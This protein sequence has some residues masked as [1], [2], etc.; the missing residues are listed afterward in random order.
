MKFSTAADNA[1]VDAYFGE[2]EQYDLEVC[3]RKPGSTSDEWINSVSIAGLFSSTGNNEGYSFVGDTANVFQGGTCAVNL[4]P[5][6][7][8]TN[9]TEQWAIFVDWNGDGAFVASERVFSG[10]GN[11][12][13]SGSFV[14]PASIPAGQYLMRV[15]MKYGSAPEAGCFVGFYYGEMED[16]FL[17]VNSNTCSTITA[18]PQ[19]I[20][21]S[22]TSSHIIWSRIPGAENYNIQWRVQGATAWNPSITVSASQGN[23]TTLTGLTTGVVYEYRIRVKCPSGFTVY[24]T[25]WNFT[26]TSTLPACNRP[27]VHNTVQ[28]SAT[29]QRIMWVHIKDATEYKIRYRT[30]SLLGGLVPAGP[31][32]NV[33]KATIITTSYLLTG[34]QSNS[35][36]DY[37][38]QSLC[39]TGWSNWSGA[40]TFTTLG[41]GMSLEANETE[42]GGLDTDFDVLISPNPTEKY[43]TLTV[44]NPDDVMFVELTNVNGQLL[45]RF[46]GMPANDRIDVSS[47][48]AGVYFI[49]VELV[50]G[51]RIVRQLVKN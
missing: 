3:G 39:P 49:R 47:L 15:F 14:V 8:N 45:D 29:R 38:I 34:L 35:R 17:R 30:S 28:V 31:W 7:S 48:P 18:T 50:T 10:S 22:L 51:D 36:Y 32:I 5:G 42:L 16:Y 12:T 43:T 37:Q 44:S 46:S 26:L 13:V 41:N 4:Y 40:G 25:I 19:V 1:C 24:S 21:A 27:L 20:Q 6:Y 9:W 11:S 33:N 23:T 2:T